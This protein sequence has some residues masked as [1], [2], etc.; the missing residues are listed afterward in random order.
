[1]KQQTTQRWRHLRIALLTMER[2]NYSNQQIMKAA[3]LRGHVIEPIDTIG[4]YTTLNALTNEIYYQGKALSFFDAIIPRIGTMVTAFGT[5]I[6]AQFEMMGGYCLNKSAAILSS[7]NKMLAHQTM[8]RSRISMPITA[9][10][11]APQNINDFIDLVGG[12]PLVIKRLQ[13]TQGEGVILANSKNEALAMID[14]LG[15]LDENFLIQE[16]IK[17]AEGADI[18]C[19]V[20]GDRVI[21]SMKRQAQPGEFRSNI[22]QGGT[23]HRIQISPQERL[24]AID[25]TRCL[26]L[27]FAGV[28]ILR[29]DKGPLVIEVNSSPG[30]FG[31]ETVNK[32]NIA[33]QII[34]YIENRLRQ[35]I[36][37]PQS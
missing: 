15:T 31:I 23:P 7:R 12:V 13:S 11:C 37:S 5:A 4:C 2:G 3:H 21:A 8:A 26:G 10:A 17:E 30:L 25:A 20:L 33:E 34:D 14:H 28:D 29:S 24:L 9:F 19:L 6:T 36:D 18:R 22:H 27:D 32:I 35:Q 1:M 16:F